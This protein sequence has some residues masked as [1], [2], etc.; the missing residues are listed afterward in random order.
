MPL[1]ARALVAPVAIVATVVADVAVKSMG[2]PARAAGARKPRREVAAAVAGESM[3]HPAR[4]AGARKPRR[5][6]A[7]AVAGE[8]MGHRERS[9]ERVD[10]GIW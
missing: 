6:V 2:H 3:G 10:F 9:R 1:Q 5:E 4:A 7:A 8:S